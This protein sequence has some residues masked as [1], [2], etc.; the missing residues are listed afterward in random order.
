MIARK[1]VDI[2]RV[3]CVS[4]I[5]WITWRGS[6]DIILSAGQSLEVRGVEDFLLEF[7]R[8]GEVTL[9]EGGDRG[10]VKGRCPEG[11]SVRGVPSP[12]SSSAA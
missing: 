5:C 12:R 11:V 9:D 10:S 4:G 3:T 6:R 2:L 1:R 7:L 8:P